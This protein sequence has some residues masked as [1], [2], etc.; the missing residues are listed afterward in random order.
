VSAAPRTSLIVAGL[1]LAVAGCSSGD[2]TD[3]DARTPPSSGAAPATAV[4]ATLPPAPTRPDDPVAATSTAAG[5]SLA[6]NASS[7]A[8]TSDVAPAEVPEMGVPGLD[9]DDAFC[10]A[11][12]RFGG[13]FQVIAVNAA[14]GDGPS[15]GLEV[16]ASPTVT[17]AYVELGENWPAEIEDER[18]AA[19]D[20]ALGPFARRLGVATDA[21]TGVGATE[22]ELEALDAAWVDALAARD[23]ED[24]VLQPDLG[25]ELQALVDS[26]AATYLDEVGSWSTDESLAND[27]A[28]PATNQYLTDNCPDQ[29]TLAGQEVGG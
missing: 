26:A 11:W 2:G 4:I 15:E 10:A 6:P 23:P 18:E 8:P 21:L 3:L 1:L 28:I 7:G 24:P 5:P 17:A 20:G 25:S 14:F 29:G 9:A 16:A 19:L 27:V 13:S 22:G 12:S